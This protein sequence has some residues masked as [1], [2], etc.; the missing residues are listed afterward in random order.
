KDE[1]PIVAK[2]SRAL[3]VKPLYLTKNRV[4]AQVV[5]VKSF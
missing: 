2:Q 5:S 1:L 3:S 4:S